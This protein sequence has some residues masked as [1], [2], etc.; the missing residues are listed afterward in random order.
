MIFNIIKVFDQNNLFFY[1]GMGRFDANML[2]AEEQDFRRSFRPKRRSPGH[3]EE[4]Q[5]AQGRV[6]RGGAR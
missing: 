3:G 6:E 4:L 1:S 2:R 5:G